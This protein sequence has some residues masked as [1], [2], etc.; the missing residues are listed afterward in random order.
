M[1]LPRAAVTLLAREAQRRLFAGSVCTLGRQHVYATAAD[2]RGLAQQYPVSLPS[3]PVELHRDPDLAARQCVSDGFLLQALGF[4]TVVRLDYSDYESPDV[5]LDLNQP[6][7]PDT[8][9]GRF[10]VVLDS[11]TIEHI[12]ELPQALR[13]CARL[14]KPGG[15]VIH[16]TPSSNS[17]D[18]GLYSVSPTLYVDFYRSC[19]YPVEQ[20]LLCRLPRRFERGSWKVYEYPLDGPQVLPLGRLG[21]GIWFTWVVVTAG[22]AYEPRAVQQSFYLNT[23]Q[24]SAAEAHAGPTDWAAREPADTRAGRLL[25]RVAGRPW[26]SRL[27]RAGILTWRRAANWY[28]DGRHPVPFRYLGRV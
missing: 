28:R 27:A 7:T 1:G 18:H 5:R 22:A 4:E 8:L 23:W 24:D 13:H 3:G 21:S 6:E 14:V 19:G 11:G 20:L 10:D 25:R 17:V 15:R 2:L 9:Q 16:L 12:F 26:L